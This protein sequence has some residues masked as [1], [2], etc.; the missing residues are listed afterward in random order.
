MRSYRRRTL[1][2]QNEQQRIE[3]WLHSAVN[4]ARTDYALGL[5]VIRLQRL[6]KGYGD[7]HARGLRNFG[8]ILAMVPRLIESGEAPR[9][10]AELH[11][12]ALA[13]DEGIALSRAIRRLE[14]QTGLP[15]GAPV[16][17]HIKE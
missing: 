14:R 2:Y 7:T 5:E 17:V 1:R 10:L 3:G 13:D 12:A 6:V 11:D 9:L 8:S 15:I 16:I 4:A